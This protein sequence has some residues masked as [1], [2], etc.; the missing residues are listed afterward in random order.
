MCHYL[1]VGCPSLN[2]WKGWLFV[3]GAIQTN[4]VG[5]IFLRWEQVSQHTILQSYTS[6]GKVES[7]N[8]NSRMLQIFLNA[9]PQ[10]YFQ[11]IYRWE[12]LDKLYHTTVAILLKLHTIGRFDTFFSSSVIYPK[13]QTGCQLP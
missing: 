10:G 11:T 13:Q 9:K 6:I 4:Q 1:P 7:A 3:F 2:A 8:I 12:R 5:P